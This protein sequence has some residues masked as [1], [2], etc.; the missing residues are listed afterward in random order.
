MPTTRFQRQFS[1]GSKPTP[2]PYDRFLDDAG[3]FRKHTARDTSSLYRV[4]SEFMYDTQDYH[5]QVRKDCVNF[6]IKHRHLYENGID[7]DFNE[8][9]KRMAKADKCGTLVELRAMG[10]M[11]KRNILV[12]E[13]YELGTWLVNQNQY[14]DDEAWRVFY[15]G[16]GSHFDLIFTKSY[17]VD[18]AFCQCK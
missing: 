5:E 3:L 10:Y 4:V 8:Y 9:V 11:F 13:P 18:A 1:A 16:N 14:A 15:L 12:F 7:G 17:A 6:M 2:D